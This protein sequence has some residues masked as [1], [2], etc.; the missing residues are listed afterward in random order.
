MGFN[1]VKSISKGISSVGKSVSKIFSSDNITST[2][3]MAGAGFLIAGPLGASIG[4]GL[5]LAQSGALGTGIQDLSTLGASAQQRYNQ[6]II[7]AQNRAAQEQSKMAELQNRQALLQQIRAARIARSNNLTDYSS[8]EGVVSS[9]ALGNISSIG[10]QYLDNLTYS[11][12][13]GRYANAAQTYINQANRYA[14]QAQSNAIKWNNYKTVAKAVA[15]YYAP[16]VGAAM[17]A[18]D[19]GNEQ[20]DLPS[21]SGTYFSISPNK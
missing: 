7:D 3:L 10:S 9:G 14:A 20:E 13:M 8:E 1:P 12:R 21:F 6:K 5:G 18:A 19:T 15:T 11:V 4:A 2:A 17:A 16:T